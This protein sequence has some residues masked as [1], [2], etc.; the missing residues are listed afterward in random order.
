MKNGLLL[1]KL[2]VLAYPA[3]SFYAYR[4]PG[5]LDAEGFV[6]LKYDLIFEEIR[7]GFYTTKLDSVKMLINKFWQVQ[8][9]HRTEDILYKLNRQIGDK[10][11][12]VNDGKLY[13]K[14][15]SKDQ[16]IE[17]ELVFGK[18]Y[19]SKFEWNLLN[20]LLNMDTV[21]AAH[22]VNNQ[23][24][25]NTDMLLWDSPIFTTN[26]LLD[27]MLE[28]GMADL[29]MHAGAA[30]KFSYVWILIMNL[31]YGTDDSK[32]NGI[33]IKTHEG[34][35]SFA[36]YIKAA[37]LLRLLMSIYFK[38]ENDIN[39]KEFLQILLPESCESITSELEIICGFLHDGEELHNKN[40]NIKS[41]FDNVL[42]TLN[43]NKKDVKA[44][45]Y[46]DE[47]LYGDILSFIFTSDFEYIAEKQQFRIIGV[48]TG[49]V[50][51]EHILMKKCIKKLNNK[52]DNYFNRLFWQ[53]TRIKNIFYTY[54]VQQHTSGKGLDVFAPIYGRQASIKNPHIISEAFYSQMNNQSIVKLELR[55]SPSDTEDN[56]KKDIYR[57]LKQYRDLLDNEYNPSKKDKLPIKS[58]RFPLIG[59][60]FHFIKRTDYDPGNYKSQAEA[61]ANLR[62]IIPNISNYIVG[63]DAASKEHN[64]EPFALREA[65]EI[66]RKN[67]KLTDGVG[68]HYIK[69][70]GFTYHVG[71]DFRDIISGLR[72]VDEVIEDFNFIAGDRLGHAI[73]IGIDIEKWAEMNSTVYIPAGE[74]F[75]NLLWEWGVYTNDE[76]YKD[77]ENIRFLENRIFDVAE[78]IFGSLDRMSVREFYADYRRKFKSTSDKPTN[79]GKSRLKEFSLKNTEKT[80]EVNISK[81]LI[82][83]YKKLQIYMKNKISEKGLI[84]EVNPTSN[85]II[86]DFATFED[87]H[88]TSLSSP[89][90]EDVIIAINTDD[91]VVFNTNLSNEFA[92]IFYIMMRTGKH[93]RKDIIQWLDKIRDNGVNYSFIPDRGL[94]RDEIIKEID[95]ILKQLSPQIP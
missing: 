83:K 64:T 25:S 23:F 78:F 58:N 15:Q 77:I 46:K 20:H 22:F 43:I 90:K 16:N 7:Q 37:S 26:P 80:I 29:H 53:Y 40:Y 93:S 30:R 39:F 19:S 2:K 5:F 36:M 28:K 62:K 49:F 51:P 85:L 86:G 70:I 94:T 52:E 38:K 74:Y 34:Y 21:I 61:I 9:P 10:Y 45:S 57:I 1:Q 73:V 87:Y 88:I 72:H 71:E 6:K 84:I 95:T 42:K 76:T 54:L 81:Q 24:E 31:I 75:E 27:K 69:T 79:E 17:N 12:Y 60:V 91:P 82:E 3:A 33:I 32:L 35:I 89:E 14:T 18:N 4:N 41:L 13:V 8:E 67:I 50:L 56:L 63:V 11:F 68:G 48:D 47:V 55:V 66:L 65:Y 59:I 92:L 44:G